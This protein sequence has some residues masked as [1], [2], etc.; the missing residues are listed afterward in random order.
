METNP[1]AFFPS[2]FVS[3]HLPT[4]N[5]AA[6]T[7]KWLDSQESCRFGRTLTWVRSAQ[8][9]PLALPVSQ[10]AVAMR[11]TSSRNLIRDERQGVVVVVVVM[12]LAVAD[13]ALASRGAWADRDVRFQ[14]TDTL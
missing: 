9:N 10:W 1:L 14:R 6:R 2:S 12:V 7:N 5:A 3:F 11:C 4:A 13:C 8:C